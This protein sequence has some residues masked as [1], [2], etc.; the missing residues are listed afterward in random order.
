MYKAN[1]HLPWLS[2]WL[3]GPNSSFKHGSQTQNCT[4]KEVQNAIQDFAMWGSSSLWTW[5][6]LPLHIEQYLPKKLIQI[7]S[8]H[9][10]WN[11]LT[12]FTY[13]HADLMYGS[14]RLGVDTWTI[15][16][17]QLQAK[18]HSKYVSC[19]NSTRNRETQS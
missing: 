11:C 19:G 16:C 10:I 1:Q 18:N 5:H 17:P 6:M 14:W 2:S 7:T 8:M 4:T 13:Y 12:G 3:S 9:C 15:I